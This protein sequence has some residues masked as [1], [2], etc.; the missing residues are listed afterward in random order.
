VKK[1][2]RIQTRAGGKDATDSV[3]VCESS[4]KGELREEKGECTSRKKGHIALAHPPS[5][6]EMKEMKEEKAKATES[7]NEKVEGNDQKD[8]KKCV[9]RPVSSFAFL[10]RSF[11][12]FLSFPFSFS[13]FLSF[14]PPRY[15]K[16]SLLV[17]ASPFHYIH[18]SP[19]L[20]R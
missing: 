1:E 6:S 13:S 20:I 18:P 2:K 4:K 12:F 10:S 11:F 17:A 19:K 3:T 15:V 14:L 9:Y 7:S 16:C 8:Q 5:S